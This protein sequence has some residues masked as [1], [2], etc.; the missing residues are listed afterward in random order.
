MRTLLLA[1]C[2]AALLPAAAG[3]QQ[4][5]VPQPQ[6][7]VTGEGEATAAPD[8][9]VVTMAVLR[10]GETARSALTA[11]NQGMREVLGALRGAGI[12]ERDIQTS[13]LSIQ[14]RY[15]NQRGC[16]SGQACDPRISGYTVSNQVTVKI[17]KIADAGEILDR[18]VG[19]GVNQ[20][21][22][23]SFALDDPKPVVTEA[24]K[25]AVADALDKARTLA[26]AAGVKLGPILTIHE[27]GQGPRPPMPYARAEMA[28]SAKAVPIA[29]G[30]ST[31]HSNVSMTFSI[32]R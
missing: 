25:R 17:R 16:V 30:E 28:M 22:H 18:V 3:A 12:A 15:A 21:G 23:I 14:P 8:M 13:G 10:E 7:V 31:Y 26:E 27:G 5:P 11:S 29:A 6:I 24:R 32:E 2:A 20:G 9:A 19:L 4:P 1:A